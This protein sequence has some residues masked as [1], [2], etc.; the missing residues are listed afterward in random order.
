MVRGVIF[1]LSSTAVV[2]FLIW[3][4]IIGPALEEPIDNLIESL[5]SN[6]VCPSEFNSDKYK[7][8]F[9]SEGEI[10]VDGIVETSTSIR[11]EEM[12]KICH[13]SAGNYDFEYT[14]CKFNN[15]KQLT[16]Y[17]LILVT[18]KGE[19]RLKGAELVSKITNK[20]EVIS[21]KGIKWLKRLKY[22]I[23]F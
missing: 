15:L 7:I 1:G 19:I 3:F 17:N 2:S 13:I 18:N 12:G 14:N 21:P 23:R 4:F 11:I 22:L 5:G 16:A 20:S 6:Y 10:V 8:C 9:N